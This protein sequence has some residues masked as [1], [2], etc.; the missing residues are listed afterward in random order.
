MAAWC[1]VVR[2]LAAVAVRHHHRGSPREGQGGDGMWVFKGKFTAEQG[3]LIARALEGEMHELFEEQRNEPSDV[4]AETPALYKTK[5]L[6][7][8]CRLQPKPFHRCGTER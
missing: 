6:K 8:D 1:S 3:A 2:P 7:M 5:I 4:S